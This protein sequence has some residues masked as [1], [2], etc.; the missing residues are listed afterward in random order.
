[1]TVTQL[2]ITAKLI[3]FNNIIWRILLG[4][5]LKSVPIGLKFIGISNFDEKKYS[6]CFTVTVSFQVDFQYRE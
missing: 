2:Y 3:E 4:G 1:M 6:E 5:T